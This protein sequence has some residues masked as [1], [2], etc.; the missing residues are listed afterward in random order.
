MAAP[1]D[2]TAL[3]VEARN[4]DADA[5]ERLVPVIH[6][7]L[8]RIARNRLRGERAGHTLQPTALI[9]EAYL[10]LLGG[11]QPH[12]ESRS[13]FF[14]V[15]A[16][17]MRQILTDHARARS[18]AKRDWRANVQLE[19]AAQVAVPSQPALVA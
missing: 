7:E 14:A 8:W 10:K 15:A 5:L 4:G 19:E 13:Q 3:L 16:R 17:L 1:A 6:Q 11:T 12:W 9:H 2:I 18:T